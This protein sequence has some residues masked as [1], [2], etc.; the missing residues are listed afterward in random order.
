[1]VLEYQCL[2]RMAALRFGTSKSNER[3][4]S[5]VANGPLSQFRKFELRVERMRLE[6]CN[7]THA[8]IRQGSISLHLP[9]SFVAGRRI[10][11]KNGPQSQR[12]ITQ[13]LENPACT[14]VEITAISK[15]ES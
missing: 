14:R 13:H 9:R 2:D 5:T 15:R 4:D 10:T 11:V 12:E 3:H 6:D 1:M 8:L 7:H